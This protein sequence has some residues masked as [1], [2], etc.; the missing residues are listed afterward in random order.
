MAIYIQTHTHI[1]IYIYVY[2]YSSVHTYIPIYIHSLH[3]CIHICKCMHACIHTCIHAYMHRIVRMAC[4][5][6]TCDN[7]CILACMHPC[8]HGCD[9]RMYAHALVLRSRINMYTPNCL[10]VHVPPCTHPA[11]HTSLGLIA[12]RTAPSHTRTHLKGM[13]FQNRLNFARRVGYHAILDTRRLPVR[14]D[15]T[16]L[17]HKIGNQILL[18]SLGLRHETR[19]RF[20]F[21][22]SLRRQSTVCASH[23]QLKLVPAL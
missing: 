4:T 6:L 11:I 23:A 13:V 8:P 20:R 2:T 18:V 5:S 17:S 9:H 10:T 21:P 16:S 3:T 7:A 19:L 22:K 15:R 12:R 1:Y 14:R